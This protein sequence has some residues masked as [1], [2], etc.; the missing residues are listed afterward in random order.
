MARPSQDRQPTR[1]PLRARGRTQPDRRGRGAARRKEE[2]LATPTR[3]AIR[4]Q[5]AYGHALDGN[6]QAS[7]RL[8]DEAHRW[9]A[10]DIVGDAHEGHG[11]Y[12]TPSYIEIQRA[13][14]WLATGKP[15]K[16]I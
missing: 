1:S 8:L 5:E 15:T 13:S 6:E 7:Q 9:A 11:S 3:A 12:C 4:V 2:Q 10:S 14:C 16:A